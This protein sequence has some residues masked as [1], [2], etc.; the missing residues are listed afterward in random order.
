MGKAIPVDKEQNMCS[1]SYVDIPP[2]ENQIS[3]SQEP[4][5]T[6]PAPKNGVTYIE[7]PIMLNPIEEESELTE[8][9]DSTCG[10]TQPQID[11]T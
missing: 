9:V 7:N 4:V 6:N 1:L 2:S 3:V 11:E 8:E 5:K 10:R